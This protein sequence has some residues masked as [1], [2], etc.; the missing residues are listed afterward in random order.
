MECH[1]CS[2][3][4]QLFVNTWSRISGFTIFLDVI[5]YNL[6]LELIIWGTFQLGFGTV[7]TSLSFPPKNRVI[8]FFIIWSTQSNLILSDVKNG[9]FCSILKSIR[10]EWDFFSFCFHLL[11]YSILR[12]GTIWGSL[13]QYK[14]WACMLNSYAYD[15]IAHSDTV[16]VTRP[17]RIYM[18]SPRSQWSKHEWE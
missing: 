17:H 8:F 12:G 16:K 14:I 5:L 11:N 9:Y 2:N 10:S 6:L 4:S 7:F 3:K 13:G 1:Q 18:P 15:I